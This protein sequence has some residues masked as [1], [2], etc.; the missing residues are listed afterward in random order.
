MSITVPRQYIDGTVDFFGYEL[1]VTDDV[2]IP[3][4]ETEL[5]VET[6]IALARAHGLRTIL[7]LGTG[8]GNIA[9]SLTKEMKH[10]RIIASDISRRALAVAREN[11]ALNGVSERISFIRSDLF[12]RV[13]S[14]FDMIISNP[15]YV[16]REEYHEL[17][18]E[19]LAEPRIALDGGPGGLEV[20]ERIV[21][22]AP[23]HLRMGGYLLLEIGYDQSARCRA[24]INASRDLR[25]VETKKDYAGIERI[26]VAKRYG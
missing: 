10:S 21:R 5:L 20:V 19:V 2:L 14:R 9:I 1:K 17:P 18:S 16:A 13:C 26:V 4:P 11:A 3:R 12:E 8:S 24:H 15:P 6:A 7:D 25:L 22:E 23:A